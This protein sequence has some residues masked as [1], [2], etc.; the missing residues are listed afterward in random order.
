MNILDNLLGRCLWWRS[1]RG[2]LWCLVGP[3]PAQPWIG[4]FWIKG[5]PRIMERVYRRE[6]H[7]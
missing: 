1:L 4:E 2:G 6:V 7:Q 5:E 3:G